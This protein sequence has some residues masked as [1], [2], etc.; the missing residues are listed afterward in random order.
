MRWRA[1]VL[2]ALA[3]VAAACGPPPPA[4]VRLGHRPNI[5]FVLTDDLSSNLVPY[6]PNV[7]ALKRQGTSMSNFYVVDSLCCPSRAATLT[8]QYPHNNGVRLNHGKDGG[9]EAFEANGDQLKTFGLTLH[10]AGYRTGFMGKYLNGYRPRYQAPD[11]GWDEWDVTGWGYDEFNYVLNENG[12]TRPFGRKPKDYLTDVLA[13]KA[14]RFIDGARTADKPFLLEVATFAPHL[15]SPPPPRYLD[16]D[17]S[18]QLPR[19]PSFN[20]LPSNPPAWL[21]GH[22]RLAA[23]DIARLRSYYLARIRADLAVDDLIGRVIATLRADGLLHDTYVVF[24]SDNGFHLGEHRLT[25]GKRTAFDTDIRVPLIV[26][27]PGVPAGRTERRLASNIDLAPTFEQIGG[28]PVPDSVDGTS[29]L[30][31]W[32]GRNP[33]LWRHAV[34]VEY[35]QPPHKDIGDPDRQGS[36]AGSPPTYDAVRTA[37]ALVVRYLTGEVEY[38]RTDRDPYELHNLGAEA[39]PPALLRALDDLSRCYGQAACQRAAQLPR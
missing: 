2:V 39:A 24:S 9:A 29:L 35:E 12:R 26:A 20:K 30:G 23:R 14:T 16:V 38:Y 21:A 19:P 28:L 8:G 13:E 1:G 17:G 4:N 5:V 22:P 36:D 10:R 37:H 7:L 31:L 3:V 25:A 11:P 27:G 6:M 34:L 15:P 18:V 32:H 33:T